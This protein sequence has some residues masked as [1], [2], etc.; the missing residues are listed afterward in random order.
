MLVFP[1]SKKVLLFVKLDFIGLFIS[2]TPCYISPATHISKLQFFRVLK[3]G[4]TV[5]SRVAVGN[6]YSDSTCTSCGMVLAFVHF[7]KCGKSLCRVV[8]GDI[9]YGD[10][11]VCEHT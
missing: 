3:Y 1:H 8:N 7:L 5:I 10:I 2:E 4:V 9:N 11:V 6:V